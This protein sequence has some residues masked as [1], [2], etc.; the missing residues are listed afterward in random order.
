MNN[1]V[2]HLLSNSSKL[3]GTK[4][5]LKGVANKD[6]RC[7][8]LASD[9]EAVV[10]NKVKSSCEKYGIQIIEYPSRHELGKLCGIEVACACVGIIK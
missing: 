5:V 2:S 7:V 9:I 3:I 10:T 8:I 4:A 6:I 1:T